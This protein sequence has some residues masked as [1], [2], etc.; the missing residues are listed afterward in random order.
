[1]TTEASSTAF[2]L[3]CG[4]YSRVVGETELITYYQPRGERVLTKAL[5]LECGHFHLIEG[6]GCET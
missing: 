3:I 5:A 6:G 2:C 4:K 1:M